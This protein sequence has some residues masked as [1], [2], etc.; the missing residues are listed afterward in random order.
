MT[1][2]FLHQRLT[3]VVSLYILELDRTFRSHEN[4]SVI[5][6]H[7]R[8]NDNNKPNRDL[9]YLRSCS[10][11]PKR[12]DKYNNDA[13]SNNKYNNHFFVLY[14]CLHPTDKIDDLDLSGKD[15]CRR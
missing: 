4:T 7:I 14:R 11:T 2:S 5:L 1:L 15:Q 13:S 6:L 3:Q 9:L 12:N 10:T 8:S